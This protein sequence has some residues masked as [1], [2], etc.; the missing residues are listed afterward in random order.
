M[1]STFKIIQQGK[2]IIT[3]KVSVY[4]ITSGDATDVTG[5]VI[6]N[7][8]GKTETQTMNSIQG[9]ADERE[10]TGMMT[11]TINI[12]SINHNGHPCHNTRTNYVTYGD[13]SSTNP[14]YF[15]GDGSIA[16]NVYGE[17]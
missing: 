6:Y 3:H 17:Y 2:E 16:I 11:I 15:S 9:F 5:Q 13:Y 12:L 1:A 7:Y 10:F 4:L 14:W 8:E